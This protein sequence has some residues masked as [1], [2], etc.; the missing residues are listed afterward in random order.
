MPK[1]ISSVSSSR[2]WSIMSKADDKLGKPRKQLPS[3]PRPSCPRQGGRHS[4]SKAGSFLCCGKPYRLTS[5]AH[6]GPSPGD[7]LTFCRY[8]LFH[9]RGYGKWTF[10]TGLKFLRSPGL[11]EGFLRWGV[12]CATLT[13]AETAP[14]RCEQEIHYVAKSRQKHVYMLHGK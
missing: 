9:Y 4:G 7:A 2:A 6:A 8:R 11:R 12:T 1:H 14:C 13:C 3:C 5:K 10:D